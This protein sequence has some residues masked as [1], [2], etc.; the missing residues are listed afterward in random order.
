MMQDR[1]T[2]FFHRLKHYT[3]RESKEWKVSTVLYDDLCCIQYSYRRLVFANVGPVKA[4]L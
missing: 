2:T 3:L 4:N 1:V